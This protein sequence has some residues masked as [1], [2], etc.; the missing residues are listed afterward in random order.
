MESSKTFDMITRNIEQK[1]REAFDEVR[2]DELKRATLEAA[3]AGTTAV[4]DSW[5]NNSAT[6]KRMLDNSRREFVRLR[7]QVRQMRHERRLKGPDS[8]DLFLDWKWNLTEEEEEETKEEEPKSIQRVR[9][10]HANTFNPTKVRQAPPPPL[11]ADPKA[12]NAKTLMRR[13]AKEAKAA[14]EKQRLM[15]KCFATQPMSRA[16]VGR[17]A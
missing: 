15:R 10:R 6:K 9:A 1:I 2:R 3:A 17:K 12:D 4:E 7:E 13:G 8:V 14:K 5:P 16:R 11:N